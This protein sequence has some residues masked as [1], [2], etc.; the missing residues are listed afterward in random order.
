MEQEFA[1]LLDRTKASFIDVLLLLFL[2]YTFS[3]AFEF[4]DNVPVNL[5][6]WLMIFIFLIYEPLANTIYTTF[7]NYIMGITVR[8]VIDTSKNLYIFK[9]FFRCLFKILFGWFSFITIFSKSKTAQFTIISV[10]V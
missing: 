7:G 5:R 1:T 10:V 4:F 2:M 6:K 9:S 8:K 3:I